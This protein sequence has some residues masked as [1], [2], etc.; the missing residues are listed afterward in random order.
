MFPS[1]CILHSIETR[2]EFVLDVVCIAIILNTWPL[3]S[4]TESYIADT[5]RSID[6]TTNTRIKTVIH[7]ESSPQNSSQF[8]N[9]SVIINTLVL[10]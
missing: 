2:H 1:C 10:K 4:I 9:T 8:S 3:E 7:Y 6:T 5:Y